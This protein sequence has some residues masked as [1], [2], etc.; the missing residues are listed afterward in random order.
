[1]VTKVEQDYIDKFEQTTPPDNPLLLIDA[2]IMYHRAA[3]SIEDSFT[4]DGNLLYTTSDRD[5]I[6]LF[7][8][9]L[10]GLLKNLEAERFLLFWSTDRNF[11][12]DLFDGYKANR[13]DMRRPECGSDLKLRLQTMYPSIVHDGLE[14]DDLMGLYSGPRT[15]I[16]SDDKDLM[17]V[18]GCH[19]RP[20]KPE[21]GAVW[22]SI[23]ESDYYWFMQVLTGDRTDGY[24]GIPGIGPVKARKLLASRGPSWQTVLKAYEDAGLPASEALLNARLARILRPGEF[25]WKENKPKLWTP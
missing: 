22:T 17:T 21:D 24:K 7:S 1:M 10:F 25:D 9:L 19:Y 11:R 5:V 20:R 2:D 16:V 3:F 13:A 18:P 6:D 23:G 15:V 12:H 14:A 8:K 4:F